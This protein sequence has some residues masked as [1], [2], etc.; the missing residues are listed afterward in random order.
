MS[1]RTTT[2]LLSL[3]LTLSAQ[4]PPTPLSWSTEVDVLP[5][6]TGGWYGSLAAG[7]GHWRFRGVVA[8][9]HLPDTFA[10]K[11]WEGARTQATA[12][13][14]DHFLR[15][16]FVG[17]WIGGGVER[18][19]ERLRAEGRQERVRLQSIQATLGG[20]WVFELGRGFT[21]NPW[22]ALHQR[23]AGDRKAIA[24]GRVCRPEPLQAE[25]S[26]KL[27]YSWH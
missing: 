25:A 15:P 24:G 8:E 3:G 18:W 19:D 6:A 20:G 1:R 13:L 23:V 17:P 5:V 22:C 9:V 10:P 26:I 7:R 11:G 2:L 27:G 4:A 16:G 12:L 14:V 21:L